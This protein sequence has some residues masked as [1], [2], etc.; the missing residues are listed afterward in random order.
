MET[1]GDSWKIWWVSRARNIRPNLQ[2]LVV[3]GM[4]L[5][6]FCFAVSAYRHRALQLPPGCQLH[7]LLA[8]T[9]LCPEKSFTEIAQ[10]ITDLPSLTA[11]M[12]QYFLALGTQANFVKKVFVPRG[13]VKQYIC[14]TIILNSGV[15]MRHHC[16]DDL[17]IWAASAL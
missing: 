8:F 10:Q 4:L 1:G 9:H 15:H 16:H 14:V 17:H 5:F 2:V 13:I 6:S 3:E 12:H 11:Q 7:R